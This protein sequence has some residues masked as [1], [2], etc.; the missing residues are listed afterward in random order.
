M[1]IERFSPSR[2]RIA[3]ARFS[4]ITSAA[5]RMVA[6]ASEKTGG[7]LI[8]SATRI[9]PSSGSAWTTW[10]VCT[11]RFRNVVAR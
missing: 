6:F 11:R 2:T 3:D 4:F 5:R 10:P 7:R 1:R 8:R 9:V